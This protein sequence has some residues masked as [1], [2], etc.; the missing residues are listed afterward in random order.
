MNVYG[1]P[2]N[3]V[4]VLSESGSQTIQDVMVNA[5]RAIFQDVSLRFTTAEARV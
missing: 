1:L 4:L 5:G 3:I 2:I